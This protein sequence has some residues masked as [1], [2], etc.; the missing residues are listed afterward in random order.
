MQ[1]SHPHS[2]VVSKGM[3]SSLPFTTPEE[4]QQ[5]SDFALVK[6]EAL[7]KRLPLSIFLCISHR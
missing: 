6:V 2:I 5:F 7:A 4:I 3:E 1:S